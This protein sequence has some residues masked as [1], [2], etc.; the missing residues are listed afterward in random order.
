MMPQPLGADHGPALCEAALALAERARAAAIVAVTQGGHT[1]RLLA[2]LRPAAR[3]IAATPNARAAA[4][5]S[6]VW[7]V[8][9][10]VIDRATIATVR[11][12]LVARAILHAGSVVVF[13][14]ISTA[15]GRHGGNFVHV[16]QL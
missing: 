11:E 15:L 13:V 2:A 7:G 3:I 14:S 9:P 6:L 5:L 10:L 1:A 8:T 4:A 12:L 16:E